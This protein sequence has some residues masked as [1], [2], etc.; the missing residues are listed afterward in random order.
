MLLKDGV[1]YELWTPKEEEKEFHPM[2]REHSKEIFGN[3]S[4]YFD[5]KHTIKS[6]SK[7]LSR[8][9]AYAITLL[10]P[11]WYIVENE[12]ATHRVYKHIVSQISEFISG[13]DNPSSQGELRDILYKEIKQN[14]V[15]KPYVE[16]IIQPEE[17]HN[18]LS[19]LMSKLPKI[20]IVI[21]QQTDQLKGAVTTLKNLGGKLKETEVVEFKT[22]VKEGTKK[23]H[24]HLFEPLHRWEWYAKYIENEKKFLCI[25][26]KPEHNLRKLYNSIEIVEHLRDEHQANPENVQIDGWNDKFEK[27]WKEHERKRNGK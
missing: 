9:D 27:L 6:K 26:G 3:D 17:L 15:L 14:K 12:L 5:I 13:I 10:E 23:D 16:K 8:P 25:A 1:Q 2:I 24:A 21:D 4:L 7:I 22:F 20:A 11:E 18:F 19:K